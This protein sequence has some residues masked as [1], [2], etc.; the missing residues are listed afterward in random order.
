MCIKSGHNRPE[1]QIGVM[2]T[3]EDAYKTFADLF[4]PIVKDLHPRYDFRYTYK[5]EELGI[6]PIEKRI[7]QKLKLQ[8]AIGEQRISHFKL[9]ARRNFRS[10]PFS[11][12]MTKEAKLQVER[13]VVEVLGELYGQ[14]IQLARLEEN[15]RL[16]LRSV[17]ISLEQD[18]EHDAAGINDDWPTGR[19]VFIHDKRQFVV[20]VNWEDHVEIVILPESLGLP[21]GS[22]VP[23]PSV[24]RD[25]LKEGFYRLIKLVQTFERLGYATDPYLGHL[26]VSPKHL[27]TAMYLQAD[28]KLE[29]RLVSQLDKRAL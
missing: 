13:K 20:L 27:G 19:G 25:S 6:E 8:E 7:K 14:Y 3:D 4:Q 18:P 16:W 17:G 10:S 23:T 9:S 5:F 11:P 2:A 24:D 29:T 26:T 15:E 1:C 28:L 21:G 22:K 12:L